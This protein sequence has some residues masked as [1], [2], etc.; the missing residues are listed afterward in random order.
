M[1]GLTRQGAT[2][3]LVQPAG[4]DRK[5]IK[6]LWIAHRPQGVQKQ[7]APNAGV[8]CEFSPAAP[9]RSSGTLLPSALPPSGC[10]RVQPRAARNQPRYVATQPWSSRA[11]AGCTPASPRYNCGGAVQGAA[12]LV[13]ALVQRRLPASRGALRRCPEQAAVAADWPGAD[14]GCRRIERA[15]AAR[16]QDALAA[17][18]CSAPLLLRSVPFS[19]GVPAPSQGCLCRSRVCGSGC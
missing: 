6:R 13:A 9:P 1:A 16:R 11:G 4:P 2:E 10:R 7:L 8:H 5:S 18:A 19:A 14:R 12:R 15:A 3:A 17:A